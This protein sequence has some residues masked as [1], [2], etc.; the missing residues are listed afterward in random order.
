MY[1]HYWVVPD[2][3]NRDV[4]VPRKPDLVQKC[5][6]HLIGAVMHRVRWLHLIIDN[7]R[8]VMEQVQRE[9]SFSW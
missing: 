2:I 9:V 7:F 3:T 4:I 1:L 5:V 8:I 6:A